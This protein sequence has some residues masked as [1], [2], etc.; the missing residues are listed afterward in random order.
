MHKSV[1]LAI[2][3]CSALFA[4]AAQAQDAAF[5]ARTVSVVIPYPPGGSADGEARPLAAQLSRLWSSPVIIESRTGAGSTVGAA[6]VAA[7]KPD[8]YTLFK[9]ATSHAISASLYPG[10]RYDP[11]KSFSGVALTVTSPFI[12]AVNAKS[13]IHT[14]AELIARAK[15]N[16]GN[17]NYGSSGIGAGPHL[18]GEIFRKAAGIEVTHVPYNGSAAALVELAGGRLDYLMTDASAIPMIKSGLVIPLAVTSPKR[19]RLLPDVPTMSELLPAA[20]DVTNWG[21]VL[22]PAGTP[23][24]IVD[25]LA[26]SIAKALEAPEIRKIYETEG[27][28]VQFFGPEE[29]DRFLAAE[30]AKYRAVIA[31]AHIMA[32]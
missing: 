11:V 13:G 8:G 26:R 29:T 22:A 2:L 20:A 19:Y 25:F 16:P 18:G 4:W 14:L 7:A 9:A 24:T 15:A 12:I 31:D 17:L 30:V 23:R 28:D 27:Y 1:T 21:S 3:G 6:Y 5:P 10:L 32:Q